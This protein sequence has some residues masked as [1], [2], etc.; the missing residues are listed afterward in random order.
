MSYQ[1]CTRHSPARTKQD[2]LNLWTF[3]ILMFF[4]LLVCIQPL[5][6]GVEHAWSL[7]GHG[8]TCSWRV[9]AQH[10]PGRCGLCRWNTK[11]C[12][13]LLLFTKLLLSCLPWDGND[14]LLVCALCIVSG[15]HFYHRVFPI[16]FYRK[17]RGENT[18]I[19]SFLCYQ[20]GFSGGISR[21]CNLQFLSL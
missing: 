19:S 16:L 11:G 7:V 15:M 6:V 2:F 17:K 20:R 9:W 13:H 5:L 3:F 12:H 14:K 10:F 21:I 4:L 1:L 18:S 8:V